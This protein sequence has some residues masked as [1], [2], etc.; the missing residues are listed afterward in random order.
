MRWDRV[1]RYCHNGTVANQNQA[2]CDLVIFLRYTVDMKNYAYTHD[3]IPFDFEQTIDRFY[4]EEL[5]L[6]RSSG[7]GKYLILK[8][9]KSDMSTWKLI[10]VISKATGLEERDIGYAGLK[11]KNATTIQYISIPK[12]YERELTN[13]TTEKIEILEKTYNKA[14]IKIGQLKGNKFSIVLHKV[15][16]SSAQKITQA[17]SEMAINGIPNYFGYQRFGE[18]NRSYLQG[19]QISESG[20]RL[21][22]AKEKLLVAS[23]QSHLFNQWLSERVKL[24]KVIK[25]HPVAKAAEEL[26]YPEALVKVL[27]R[28]TPF[29]KLFIG[30]LML[31]YPYGKSWYLKDMLQGSKLFQEKKSVPTG[32]ISGSHALRSQSDA[33]HLESPYDDEELSALKGDRRFAW[34]WPEA[35]DTRYDEATHKL[36]IRFTLLKG[37]YATTFLEEIGKISLKP[38][39]DASK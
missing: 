26:S 27:S 30:D 5:P 17:A 31:P 24:S 8:I 19:K 11:D 32:L 7:H 1:D 10:H 3:P 15:T 37:A 16:A 28:Q 20:K 12:Q 4:V 38:T 2:I 23:Y 33:Y 6:F 21:K 13:L 29:L 18:D 9:K 36:T 22:G 14:P 25:S 35:V 39:L 34:I